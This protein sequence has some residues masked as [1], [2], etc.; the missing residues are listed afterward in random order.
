[1]HLIKRLVKSEGNSIADRMREEAV[2]LAAQVT[3]VE[4][5]EAISALI[6]K[7]KPIF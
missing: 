1:L 6:E 4:G 2:A 5:I 7:R 3:S